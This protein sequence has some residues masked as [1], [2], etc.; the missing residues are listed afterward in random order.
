MNKLMKY[1]KAPLLLAAV[2]VVAFSL[3]SYIKVSAAASNI[4]GTVRNPSNATVSGAYIYATAPSSS[5][6]VYGPVTT[7][8]SGFYTLTINT[9]GTY[10]IH[11]DPPSN[12]G[13][14]PVVN[15]SVAVSSDQTINATFSSQ[16]NTL[17]GTLT[18]SNNTP[19]A[20]VTVKIF[21]GSSQY[22]TTTDA[23]GNYSLSAPAGYYYLYL[24]GSMT[25]I[26]NFTLTQSNTSSLNLLSGNLSLNL[27]IKLAT[28]TVTAYN[29]AGQQDYGGSPS[30]SA[31]ATSG[32]TS[33]YPGDPGTTISV[34]N[35]TGFSTFSSATGTITTIVGATYAAS[36]L[37]STSNTTSVCKSISGGSGVYDCLRLPLT[38]SGNVT[39]DLPNTSPTTRT[40]SGTLTDSSGAPI[41]GAGVTL[42]KY[43][44]SSTTAST[45][46]SGNFTISAMPK[47]YYLKITGP[48]G[49][50]N[51]LSYVLTQ[52]STNPSIDLTADSK[53]QNLQVQTA[54]LT[55]TANDA[56]GNPNYFTTVNAMT[57]TGSTTLYTGDPGETL[58]IT[59]T[60]FSTS[61]SSVTG[62]IG[63]IVGATYSAKGLNV[64]SQ[65]GS[66]CDGA[67]T[68]GHYNC[69]T[70]AYTVTGAGSLNVPF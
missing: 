58:S 24:T 54:T 25:G 7:N 37:E 38:V 52:S 22:Q 50:N 45:D 16:T 21:K 56:S 44:D 53:T 20:G 64:T 55:V 46:S 57:T 66:I 60:G 48:S 17:S 3:L 51:M 28:M 4:T 11:I 29:N 18:D 43:G 61:P 2:M 67:A 49:N 10:D 6:P 19:L 13:W 14:F 63:T 27:S 36:G 8:G 62:S 9:P 41:V 69:L 23:S 12:N 34:V 26:P 15:S 59:S 30:V 42:I 31:R 70:T 33:L 32:I 1:R 5:T 35:S 65:S 40:F 39:F 68:S 47:K